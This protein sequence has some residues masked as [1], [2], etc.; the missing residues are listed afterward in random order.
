VVPVTAWNAKYTTI[1]W[2]VFLKPAARNGLTKESAADC[3]QVK[4]VSL[5]RFVTK[6]GDLRADTVEEIST[7]IALCVGA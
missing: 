1:P 3:F 4:S 7:A 6:L 5:D 2:L